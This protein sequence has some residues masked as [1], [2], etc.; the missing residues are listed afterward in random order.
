MNRYFQ[1][2]LK[3][4]FQLYR[5]VYRRKVINFAFYQQDVND[6]MEIAYYQ[7]LK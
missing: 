5:Q 1:N 3:H 7:Q 2:L 4:I 6:E